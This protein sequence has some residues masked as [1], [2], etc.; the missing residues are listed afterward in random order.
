MPVASIREPAV[1]GQFYPGGAEQLKEALEEMFPPRVQSQPAMAVMLPHA[2][3]VYSGAIAAETL[4]RVTIPKRVMLLGPN[5]HGLGE[6]V[7]LVTQQGWRTPFGVVQ[8][9]Q[10]LTRRM[11]DRSELVSLSDS[12]H[13]H[14]HSLEVQVPLLQYLQPELQI[15]PISLMHL[16]LE[17]LL[18][19]GF[20]IATVI[21]E[22]PEPVLLV[23]S[24]DMTHFESAE[25][26]RAK[27]QL[28]LDQVLALNPESL[29]RTVRDNRISMC[30]MIATVVV[31]EACRRLGASGVEL[32]RYGNSGEVNGDMSE[33]VGYAGAVIPAVD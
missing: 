9:D 22:T 6:P 3:Y 2:G 19:L 25:A 18:A 10:D 32:V 17:R 4:A 15:T 12:S 8:I 5:H 20:A 11:L 7:G 24:T 21:S 30:G 13:R 14:E 16:S 29:Y 27:D 1:A 26:A 31:L 28:A 23:A 33:V